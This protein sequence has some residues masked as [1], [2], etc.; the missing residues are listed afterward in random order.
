MP[1]D[2]KIKQYEYIGAT[3]VINPLL[4]RGTIDAIPV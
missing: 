4:L 1:K 3:K 2:P